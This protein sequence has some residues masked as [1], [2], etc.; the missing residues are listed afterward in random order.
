MQVN[1]FSLQVQFLRNMS[2]G[3][4][5]LKLGKNSA[6]LKQHWK[7][8]F[9]ITTCKNCFTNKPLIKLARK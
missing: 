9:Q 7:A 5:S 3:N 8:E 6:T 2:I 1:Q 4:M